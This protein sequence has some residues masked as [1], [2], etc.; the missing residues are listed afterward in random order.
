MRIKWDAN[1]LSQFYCSC[2]ILSV[3][4]LNIKSLFIFQLSNFIVHCCRLIETIT[5]YFFGLGCCCGYDISETYLK[6]YMLCPAKQ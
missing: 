6:R 3:Y 4:K 2:T 1:T 5:E